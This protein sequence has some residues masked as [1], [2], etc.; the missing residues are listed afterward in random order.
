MEIL[1]LSRGMN[2]GCKLLFVIEIRLKCNN[3]DSVQLEG[4][5]GLL[6]FRAIKTDLAAGMLRSLQIIPP[7]LKLNC[8]GNV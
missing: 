5:S 4:S 2:H 3:I 8:F 1:S 7:Q 6:P